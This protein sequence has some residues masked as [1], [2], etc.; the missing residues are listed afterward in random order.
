LKKIRKIFFKKHA[1]PSK[2]TPRTPFE[3]SEKQ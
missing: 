1:R 2:Y 3:R